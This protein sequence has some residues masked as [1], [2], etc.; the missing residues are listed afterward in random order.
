MDIDRQLVQQIVAA[1]EDRLRAGEGTDVADSAAT[2]VPCPETLLSEPV[3]TGEL[4]RQR[5]EPGARSIRLSA[6][7]ILT[8]TAREVI[9][10]RDLE[11]VRDSGEPSSRTVT[12]PGWH[13]L[14]SGP[15]VSTPGSYPGERLG[16]PAAT[17]ARVIELL[18]SA[19]IARGVLVLSTDPH[20]V[21]CLANR[22]PAVRGAVVGDAEEAERVLRQLGANLV[23]ACPLAVGV[24]KTRE[25]LESCL[26]TLPPS[27]PADWPGEHEGEIP[28]STSKRK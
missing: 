14:L 8:P 24:L 21:T 11:C 17:V 20:R 6:N 15:D 7:T 22:S 13:L 9:R 19:D 28:S 1:V 5:L 2:V 26:A 25:I 4:L 27:V 3:V 18:E 16:H 12:A 23:V 10:Q